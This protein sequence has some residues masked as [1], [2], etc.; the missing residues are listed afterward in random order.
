[1]KGFGLILAIVI[2][3]FI[4][5]IYNQA[6]AQENKT[7]NQN[8]PSNSIFSNYKSKLYTGGNM[9]AQFGN[10]TF[11]D[12]SPILGYRFT[13]DFS[14]GI[15]T[16]YRYLRYNDGRNL[17]KNNILG[18][19]VFGRYNVF[20]NLF[21]YSEYEV[22]NSDWAQYGKRINVENLLAGL[23]YTQFLGERASVSIMGLWNFYYSPFPI[24]NNPIIRMGFNI[25]L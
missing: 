15:G 8:T 14:A 21:V 16:T 13:E 10:S 19:R 2:K 11:I 9:G 23:G 20:D 3:L 25:G 4:L 5:G 18:G 1:M 22:L 6:L 17:Y 24:Y 7:N 12:I